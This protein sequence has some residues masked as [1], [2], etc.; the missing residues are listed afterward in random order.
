MWSDNLSERE[1]DF[2]RRARKALAGKRWAEPLLGRVTKAGGLVAG[3]MP[4]LFEIRF[5]YELYRAGSTPEYEYPAGVGQ[6]TVE[7]RIPISAAREWLVELVSIRASEPAKS[8]IRETGLIY[9]QVFSNAA[10]DRK[11]SEE[12]EMITAEQK[13]GEKVFA[14]GRPTK[15]P[16]PGASALHAIVVDMRGYLDGGGD[17]FDYR[18]MAYG[19]SGIPAKNKWMIHYWEIKPGKR[20]PIAGLFEH[21]N[22]LGAA[23]HVRERI[24]FLGFVCERE[25]SDGEI[26][27]TTYYLA[28]PHLFATKA[29]AQAAFATFPLQPR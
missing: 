28:N 4:L 2:T 5:A 10:R 21:S 3:A 22:R 16:L 27:S 15:F 25:Y 11:Q 23:R 18:Q 20:Q 17:V 1:A 9:Q 8:A 12:A 13:I 29:A 24:H 14:R 26:P 19:A 7:F 6:S